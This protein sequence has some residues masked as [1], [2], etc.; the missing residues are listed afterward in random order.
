MASET[1]CLESIVSV[2]VCR[3]ESESTSGFRLVDAAGISSTTL[4]KIADSDNPT[5]IELA[6]S[7]K[8]LATLKV[9]N[10]FMSMMMTN[11]VSS[12]I[13]SKSFSS[14]SF[15]D[16]VVQPSSSYH[17]VRIHKVNASDKV[18]RMY[19]KSV[20]FIPNISG[21]VTIRI[22]DGM[23]VHNA[24]VSAVG[25]LVNTVD[26]SDITGYGDLSVVSRNVKVLIMHEGI[27]LKGSSVSCMKGCS[28]RLPNPCGWVDG[29]SGTTA[30]KSDGFGLSV[31]FYCD[32][33]Y[34][35]VLCHL[36]NSVVG[37]LVFIAWQIE[38]MQEQLLSSRFNSIVVYGRE[39]IK[40]YWLP[41]L[42]GEYKSKWA[43]LAE[44]IKKYVSSLDSDCVRCK[45]ARWV[46]N[47]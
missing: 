29:W 40:D 34:D 18:K 5:G 28:G 45:G 43:G 14:S 10:D 3:D 9:R 42:I 27:A 37:E 22:E 17:G 32:C 41:S 6:L 47:L 7:K 33:D 35:M 31:D 39:E 16:K 21:D 20:S 12:D 11:S 19:L 46:T 24:V 8:K 44:N 1:S 13:S 4:A 26:V 36:S 2:G 25:G 38:I 30:V 23:N 15:N